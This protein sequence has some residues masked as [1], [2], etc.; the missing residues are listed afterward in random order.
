[1]VG[2][3]F[4]YNDKTYEDVTLEHIYHLRKN[5]IE[6][7]HIL[8]NGEIIFLPYEEFSELEHIKPKIIELERNQNVTISRGENTFDHFSTPSTSSQ[9]NSINSDRK[10]VYN[11]DLLTFLK[12][13]NPLVPR[14]NDKSE[15]LD[16]FIAQVEQLQKATPAHLRNDLLDFVKNRTSGATK[17]AVSHCD[18]VQAIIDTLRNTVLPESS[19][20]LESKLAAIRFDNRNLSDFTE[21]VEKVSKELLNAYV[22]EGIRIDKATQLATKLVV[23]TC[24]HSTRFGHIKTIMAAGTFASPRD[25]LTKFRLEVA[26]QHTRTRPTNSNYQNRPYSGNQANYNTNRNVPFNP[27]TNQLFQSPQPQA[28]SQPGNNTNPQV[29]PQNTNY[30]T[31][32]NNGFVQRTRTFHPRNNNNNHVRVLDTEDDQTQ[33]NCQGSNRQS[34]L[35]ES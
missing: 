35:D 17:I 7:K 24:K 29:T 8:D 22:S 11:M 33:E 14:F 9:N 34:T 30:S 26:D 6:V 2:Y 21:S 27:R 31:P 12:I 4:I 32:V 25:A 23:E 16:F 19:E 10:P 28:Y 5:Q 20:V 13:A 1:M 18:C 15:D 3:T